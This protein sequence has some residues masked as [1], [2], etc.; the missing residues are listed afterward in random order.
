M[1]YIF[2]Q[3]LNDLIEELEQEKSISIY[4]SKDYFLETLKILQKDYL[5]EKK[6]F[7]LIVIFGMNILK[8]YV[9]FVKKK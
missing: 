1:I 7:Y 4:H 2:I 5:K 8:K 3:N 6:K 9:F